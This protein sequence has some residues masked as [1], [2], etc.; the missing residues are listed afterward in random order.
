VNARRTGEAGR[1]ADW[2]DA[3][4]ISFAPEAAI[5]LVE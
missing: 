4:W 3:V 5:L 2:D 1:V